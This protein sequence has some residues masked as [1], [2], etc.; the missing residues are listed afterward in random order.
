MKNYRNPTNVHPPLAGYSHQIEI[1]GAERL[2]VLSGQ[3]GRTEEGVVPDDGFEQ[4]KLAFDNL[5]RNLTA[6]NMDI[7]DVVKITL[8]LVGEMDATKRREFTASWLRGHKP[9]MTVVFVAALATPV[10]K[11]EVDAW[12]SSASS[13]PRSPGEQSV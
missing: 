7:Q 8:F 13:A 10:Y 4:L 2:L 1:R 5:Q 12:A 11:V 9:C 3:V 6:A